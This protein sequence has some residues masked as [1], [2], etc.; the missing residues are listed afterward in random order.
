MSEREW[1]SLWYDL[2]TN[3]AGNF[4]NAQGFRRLDDIVGSVSALG[5]AGAAGGIALS[6]LKMLGAGT[7]V[8]KALPVI[9]LS[10][11]AAFGLATYCKWGERSTHHQQTGARYN[12][13]ARKTEHAL[14]NKDARTKELW[15]EITKERDE[16]E[17]AIKYVVSNRI[18][19]YA[20]AS[21]LAKKVKEAEEPTLWNRFFGQLH[22][23]ND[24]NKAILMARPLADWK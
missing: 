8:G 19:D 1:K 5:S 24:R 21:V 17:H 16:A 9:A 15:S 2:K 7:W 6:Q 4:E 13:L 11:F 18:Q 23:S 20:R 3:A 10:S 14:H 12:S 22:D